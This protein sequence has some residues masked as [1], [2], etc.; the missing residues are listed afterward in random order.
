MIVVHDRVL[1]NDERKAEIKATGLFSL[2]EKI[3]YI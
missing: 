1:S 2:A 3:E